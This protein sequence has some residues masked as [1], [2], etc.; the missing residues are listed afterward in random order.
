MKYN[1][2]WLKV[3]YANEH[4]IWDDN[5]ANTACRQL[6]YLGGWPV[7]FNNTKPVSNNRYLCNFD[8]K[9]G[10]NRRY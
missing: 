4:Y 1:T 8:C 5:A 9:R 2:E 3:C 7:S 10:M 6:K